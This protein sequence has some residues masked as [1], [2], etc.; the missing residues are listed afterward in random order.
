MKVKQRT[1][2]EAIYCQRA[3]ED[4]SMSNVVHFYREEFKQILEG[5]PASELFTTNARRR[6]LK[7]GVLD[8]VHEGGSGRKTIITDE[9]LWFLEKEVKQDE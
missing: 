9:A 2:E 6:M 1:L 7:N 4:I 5:V 3:L 8:T